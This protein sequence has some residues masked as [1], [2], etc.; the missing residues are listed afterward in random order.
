MRGAAHAK[1]NAATR[2][3]PEQ[4]GTT[5]MNMSQAGL[6]R[7]TPSG[8]PE[9]RTDRL[10]EALLALGIVLSGASQFRIAG[11]PVGP[12][13]ACLMGWAAVRV[14]RV[15]FDRT[16]VPARADA[17]ILIF[18]AIVGIG[19]S[20]GLLAAMLTN[21]PIDWSTTLHD[22]TAYLLMAL[23]SGFS[24]S[25]VAIGDSLSRVARAV[26]VFAT[27][28]LGLQIAA[29]WG[30][31]PAPGTG[32][33][34]W[35]RFRGWADN[36]NQLSLFCAMVVAIAVF[37]VET[38]ERGFDRWM[39]LACAGTAL[40]TGILTKGN[41][42]RLS[43]A[44]GTCVFVP[45]LFRKLALQRGSRLTVPAMSC[46][47][48]I[49]SLPVAGLAAVPY[50]SQLSTDDLAQEISRDQGETLNEADLRFTLW[51]GAIQGGLDSMF[52][53][54]G[55]GPH[56]PVPADVTLRRVWET[57]AFEESLGEIAKHA[58]FMESHNTYIELFSQ[59]GLLVIVAYGWLL[60]VAARRA[61]E[62][63]SAAL[64][65]LLCVLLVFGIFHVMLRHPIV[66]FALCLC[67]GSRSRSGQPRESLG[68]WR[69]SPA[70]ACS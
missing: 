8:E 65:T 39:A 21:V 63:R 26:M 31:L 27:V 62:S 45:L 35:D 46:I 13:E 53:G 38:S 33:W 23:I 28:S 68:V 10:L 49:A 14:S 24:L 40:T 9:S 2:R 69:T 19:Q 52:L 57:D 56:A 64:P 29:G 66:W 18:W 51:T 1:L 15:L 22:V 5:L 30:L 36:P 50:I 37:M 4:A 60:V 16:P 11:L 6:V 70:D 20:V 25:G 48:L 42:F 32:P 41:T 3:E 67:L 58:D 17:T 59:G 7:L 61:L 12:G 43:L 44:V 34:Y 54:L 55:P 47:L